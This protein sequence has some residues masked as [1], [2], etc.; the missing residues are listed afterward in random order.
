MRHLVVA[1]LM[2]SLIIVRPSFP[3]H[4]PP[5]WSINVVRSSRARPGATLLTTP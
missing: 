2:L 4:A 1:S 5:A 3:I